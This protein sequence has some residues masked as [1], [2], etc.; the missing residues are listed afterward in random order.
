VGSFGGIVFAPF[1]G[2]PKR[3]LAEPAPIAALEGC[4]NG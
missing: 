3:F 1:A 2:R 4:W